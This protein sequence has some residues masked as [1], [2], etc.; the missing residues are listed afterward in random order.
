MT[1][2]K[3]P[4]PELSYLKEDDIDLDMTGRHYVKISTSEGQL[5]EQVVMDVLL[6]S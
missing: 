4:A 3:L 6:T 2:F 5:A 1:H